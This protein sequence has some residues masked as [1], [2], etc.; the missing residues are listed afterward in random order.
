MKIE[1]FKTA[2]ETE[3]QRL[4]PIKG[5]VLNERM[6]DIL[7]QLPN[8]HIPYGRGRFL[9]KTIEFLLITIQR[10]WNEKEELSEKIESIGK[11]CSDAWYLQRLQDGE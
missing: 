1:I 5:D 4:P 3:I 8:F 7:E 9:D 11:N 2:F 10:L 6:K